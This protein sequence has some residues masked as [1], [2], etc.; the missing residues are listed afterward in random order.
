[1][2]ICI[3]CASTNVET[4]PL[5]ASDGLEW[6]HCKDCGKEWT[7]KDTYIKLLE[8]T[9]K[10]L[11]MIELEARN[12]FNIDTALTTMSNLD[13]GR[14]ACGNLLRALKK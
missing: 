14:V 4:N 10:N 6:Y 3:K 9:I 12:W 11:K 7:E 5:Y 2:V 13:R 8:Q 1:M